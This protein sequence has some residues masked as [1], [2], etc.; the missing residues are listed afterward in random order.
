MPESAC[1]IRSCL[2]PGVLVNNRPDGLVNLS[3]ILINVVEGRNPQKER[4][5]V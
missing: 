2:L 3:A 1:S 4:C 5:S